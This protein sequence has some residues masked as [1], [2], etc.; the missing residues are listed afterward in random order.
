MS[1]QQY[2]INSTTNVLNGTP[3]FLG[4]LTSASATAP[5]N[6]ATT[7]VPFLFAPIQPGSSAS[8]GP[9][10]LN[11]TLAGKTLLLQPTAQS[12]ILPSG[13]ASMTAP[14]IVIARQTATPTASVTPGIL[15][16]ANERVV[17]VMGFQMGWL[18]FLG[19]AGAASLMVWEMGR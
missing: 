16:A 2:T 1:A 17:L 10:N 13:S 14:Q 5:V 11:G 9:V 6:N 8:I 4:V 18:Q 15:L 12:L 19:D 7:A 3:R